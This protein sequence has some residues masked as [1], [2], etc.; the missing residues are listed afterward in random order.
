MG[1]SL[2]KV[3]NKD[4]KTVFMAVILMSLLLLLSRYLST[5]FGFVSSKR[6]YVLLF[7]C[8]GGI[9][10]DSFDRR[11]KESIR[12]DYH[13]YRFLRHE[14]Q[15]NLYICRENLQILSLLIRR[16]TWI[17]LFRTSNALL[18][19]NKLHQ[20]NLFL[21]LNLLFVRYYFVKVVWLKL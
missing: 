8:F 12:N 5:E 18:I 7:L 13:F 1:R 4:T 17:H 15:K 14:H 9:W 19:W 11:D 21:T 3:S 6:R 2:L 16:K 20:V 10:L